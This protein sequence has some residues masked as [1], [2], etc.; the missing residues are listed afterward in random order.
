MDIDGVWGYQSTAATKQFQNA[1]GIKQDGI[2]GVS[3]ADKSREVI[4]A[5]QDVIIRYAPGL[6]NDGLAG[7]AT[8]AATKLYQ[9][10]NGLA[11]DG[12][13]GEKTRAKIAGTTSPTVSTSQNKPATGTWWDEIEYIDPEE[14]ACKCGGRYC[15]GYPAQM[16]RAVVEIAN[17]ARKHFGKPLVVI[18]GLRCQ[19]HNANEGG[20]AN[21]QHMY[22]EAMDI[23]IPGVTGDELLAWIKQQPGVRYAYKINSTNVHF[24][25]PKGAR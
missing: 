16:Q 8:V 11:A 25:I 10:S 4:D 3:T 22:G 19:R 6:I 20:V 15:S 1:F 12:R 24:D 7:P 21:S 2:F 14:C 5:I 23:K 18:S 9:Q 13:A 17:N